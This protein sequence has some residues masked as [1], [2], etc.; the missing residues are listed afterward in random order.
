M[1]IWLWILTVSAAMVLPPLGGANVPALFCCCC[2]MRRLLLLLLRKIFLHFFFPI[3]PLP[4]LSSPPVN[5]ELPSM[6]FP[7]LSLPILTEAVCYL[8]TPSWTLV[9]KQSSC[10]IIP[11][12]RKYRLSHFLRSFSPI[13]PFLIPEM[14]IIPDFTFPLCHKTCPLMRPEIICVTCVVCLWLL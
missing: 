1:R 2:C 3:Q 8:L 10:L 5:M 7:I 12:Y 13:C 6:L 11:L 9:H 14:V 4:R